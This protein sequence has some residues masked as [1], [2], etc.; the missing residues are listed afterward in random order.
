[1]VVP[2]AMEAFKMGSQGRINM[3]RLTY[4]ILIAIPIAMI[5]S[6][7]SML[8]LSYTFEGG[9]LAIDDYRFVHVATR[10]FQEL[11][12]V[13]TDPGG[14]SITRVNFIAGATGFGI[15]LTLMRTAL[16]VVAI[17]PYGI[18]CQHNVGYEVPVVVDI[19][20]VVL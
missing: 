20:G 13:L 16:L 18:R 7:W 2:E 1:M 15:F 10:P 12:A 4:A 14:L 6:Y 11:S 19:P 5:V 8:Y 9:G 17:P 3:R